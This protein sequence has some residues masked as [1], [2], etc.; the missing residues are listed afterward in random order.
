MITVNDEEHANRLSNVFKSEGDDHC[1]DVHPIIIKKDSVQQQEQ[2]HSHAVDP[3]EVSVQLL[4][5]DYS[6]Y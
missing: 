2:S 4:D 3:V 1:L 5:T 6:F